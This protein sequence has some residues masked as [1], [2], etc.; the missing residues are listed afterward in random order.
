MTAA[1]TY[2][3]LQEDL[4]TYLE[5]GNAVSDASVFEQFPRLIN[6]AEREIVNTA[7]LLGFVQVVTSSL[8]A[9][10]SVYEKPDRWRRT[11][12]FNFGVG[13]GQTRTELYPRVYEYLRQFWPDEEETAQP[14]FYADYNYQN[15][16]VAPTPDQD[17]PFE[18]LY[19]EQPAYL[20][21]D[22]ETNWLTDYAPNLLLYGTLLQCEPFLKD[23]ERI[24]TWKDF[25]VRE[26]QLLQE[27]EQRRMIDRTAVRTAV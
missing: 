27:Q 11:I 19:Y 17:Y 20:G 14:Q 8:T 10:T 13:T 2:T 3:S 22:N 15:W 21:E 25:Y 9:G 5:R 12:S 23:D 16:L 6:L 1:M 26:L 18:V 7:D 24:A 4:Q